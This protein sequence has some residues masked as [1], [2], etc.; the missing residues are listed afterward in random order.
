MHIKAQVNSDFLK[1]AGQNIVLPGSR[2]QDTHGF[3]GFK[4]IFMHWSANCGNIYLKNKKVKDP[5]RSKNPA[6][7]RWV[8]E[9]P[10]IIVLGW[11]L[12]GR[13]VYWVNRVHVWDAATLNFKL[14]PCHLVAGLNWTCFSDLKNA[15]DNISFGREHCNIGVRG[16]CFRTVSRLL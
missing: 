9:Y 13:L 2:L 10:R 15:H 16:S 4:N 8:T 1:W 11:V 7:F 3:M 14:W 5:G 6:F 12:P